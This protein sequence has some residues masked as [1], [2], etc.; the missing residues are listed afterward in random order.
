MKE[1][2]KNQLKL[3]EE[4]IFHDE[5]AIIKE[6]VNEMKAQMDRLYADKKMLR[7]IHAKMHGCVKAKFIVEPNLDKKYKIG[8]F[9]TPATYN[10]WV[11]F[12]NSNSKPQADKKK[13]IRGIAIKLMGVPGEKIINHKKQYSSQDFLLMS[14]E[15]FFSKNIKEFRAT[16]KASTSKSKIKLLLYFLNPKHW[17][18]F[19]RLM[20]TF[21]KCENPLAIPYWSTQ[22]Y[23]F[24]A[25]NQAVKY[26][27]KPWQNN[28]LIN[29]NF[30]EHDYLR[31]NMAQ[32]LNSYST[33]FDFFV[34]FQGDAYTMPIE[35]S[36]IP[37]SSPFIKLATLEILP[38][39]FDTKKQLRFGEDLH[40]NSWHSL[41]EHRP[42]GNFN[43]ARKRV[44][45]TMATYRYEKNDITFKEPEDSATF[46]DDTKQPNTNLAIEN[47][48]KKGVL[49]RSAQVLVECSKPIAFKFITSKEELPN[50]L[51]KHGS[52]PAALYAELVTDTYNVPGNKREVY[53]DHHES[54]L[55]EL[56]S[57]NPH[58]NYSYKITNFTNSIKH[59]SKL[60]YAEA[61]FDS[62][63][64]K[65]RITWDY[66]FT[67][68]NIF[69]RMI[70]S[71]IL[72]FIFK[73]FMQVSL[74]NAKDCIEN[75]D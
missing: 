5:D 74:N 75:G 28:R 46:L 62:I 7:Q 22:P 43:R 63:D 13:D 27:I 55:E 29:E 70:L 64:G 68:K 54:T 42:L 60:A 66:Y 37:W 69:A 4:Y 17:S 16:L 15:T 47:I 50:W 41:P 39:E 59:F 19:K 14:S 52:L 21:V 40:F 61:W 10:S 65:T 32:T 73:K 30:K 34:Q 26:Y 45:E 23:R 71:I 8:V 57:Y 44:Y 49:K 6:M 9:K 24:G 33:K 31:V 36:T 11:R 18:L 25:L 38:Q 53:F 35:D 12:S 51:K 48:P 72:T 2:S 58:S 20:K 3:G 56:L 1:A 67:Y